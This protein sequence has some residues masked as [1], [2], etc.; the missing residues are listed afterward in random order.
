MRFINDLAAFEKL[1]GRVTAT[2]A[3]IRENLFGS[4]PYAE[5]VIAEDDGRPAGFAVFFPTFS[6]FRGQPG[7]YLEDL[8]VQPEFRGRGI[9]R[10][11]LAHLAKLARQR[12][13]CK[14][15]WVVLDWN[16]KA[17]GF[18]ERLGAEALPEWRIYRVADEALTALAQ[19]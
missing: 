3:Q 1:A 19:L 18:Y 7:L 2:P 5:A 9:G 13:C 14:F 6:T 15:E 4:R 8:F 17:M 16:D 11:L 10:A 12:G